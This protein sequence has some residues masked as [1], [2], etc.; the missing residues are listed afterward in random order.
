[1][2]P[3]A[4]RSKT[5]AFASSVL[6]GLCAGCERPAMS[7]ITLL[8]TPMPIPV[9]RFNAGH[10][11]FT[12]SA[13]WTAT[14]RETAGLA[15]RLLEVDTTVRDNFT[16]AVLGEPAISRSAEIIT[17]AG[18]DHVNPRGQITVSQT[19]SDAPP[20]F[21]GSLTFDVRASFVDDKGHTL[22]ASVLVPE[23]SPGL[24]CP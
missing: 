12:R 16:G 10:G 15:G 4:R 9:A 20:F 14:V 1:M 5:R 24:P 22:S 3:S 23:E 17:E 19:W 6:L 21:C 7:V 2:T 13:A 8:V 18:T 11:R